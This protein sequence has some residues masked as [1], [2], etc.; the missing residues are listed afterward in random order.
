MVPDTLVTE[1]ID[2]EALTE[3]DAAFELLRSKLPEPDIQAL[4]REVIT[5]IS[6]RASGALKGPELRSPIAVDDLCQ[7]LIS[8]SPERVFEVMRDLLQ[9][10]MTVEDIYVEHLVPAA[11]RLGEYWEA[12]TASFSEVTIGT[13]RIYTLMQRLVKSRQVY[14]QSSD[15]AAIVATLEGEQHTLG[16]QM[17]AD[18]ARLEGWDIRLRM[19][20]SNE[21]LIKEAVQSSI[22][23]F[24]IA[25]TRHESL[26]AVARLVTGLRLEAPSLRILVSGRIADVEREAVAWMMP[27][28][29]ASTLPDAMGELERLYDMNGDGP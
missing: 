4:A 24:A 1:R 20:C 17:A 28:G 23:V 7:A 8:P 27:D 9:S 16:A 12:D 15:R 19:D 10:D 6:Q 14:Q 2:K 11:R 3:S 5:R 13:S 21:A 29:L 25:A 22:D 26:G 18:V